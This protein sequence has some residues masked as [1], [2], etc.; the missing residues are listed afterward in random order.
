[1]S[2]IQCPWCSTLFESTLTSCPRCGASADIQA[3]ADADGWVEAP[4]IKDMAELQLGKSTAQIEGVH[5]PVV[6]IRLAD[7]EEVYA[8][9]DKLLWYEGGIKLGNKKVGDNLFHKTRVVTATGPGRIAFS[10]NLPGELIAIPL[11]HGDTVSVQAH[12]LLLATGNVDYDNKNTNLWYQTVEEKQTAD[13]TEREYETHYPAMPFKEDFSTTDR[14]PGLLMVHAK[15]N[16]FVR[17]LGHGEKI[18][19]AGHSLVAWKGPQHKLRLDKHSGGL[20]N[21]FG[22][23]SSWYITTRLEGPGRVWIQSGSH[24]KVVEHKKISDTNHAHVVEF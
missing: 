21:L 11:D 4:G 12:H 22:N 20:K 19:V 2:Q 3:V 9:H 14:Q 13:G 24:G 18:D 16:V 17:E 5:V 1:M 8:H 7:G 10:D 15:G 6:D 23:H